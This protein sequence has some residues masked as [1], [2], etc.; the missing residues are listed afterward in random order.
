MPTMSQD[1][2]KAL[3]MHSRSAMSL[4]EIRDA[5]AAL[6]PSLD[7]FKGGWASINNYE[8]NL[9]RPGIEPPASTPEI[10]AATDVLPRMLR[11]RFYYWDPA[12]AGMGDQQG[13]DPLVTRRLNAIDVMITEPAEGRIG[14]LFSTRTPSYLGKGDGIIASLNKILQTRDATIKVDRRQSHLRLMDE[15]IFL[16]LA[17]QHRDRPQLAADIKLDQIAGISS[18]DTASRTADLRYGVD[19]ERSNFLTAVAEKDTLGPIDICFVHH[20]GEENHSYEVRLHV[21]GGFEVRRNSLHFPDMLDRPELM[22]ETSLFLAYSLIPRF[23]A[24][25][26]ADAANWSTQRVDVIQSAMAALEERYKSL[27]AVL[28]KQL[29]GSEG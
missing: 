4:E 14:L 21:D 5:M 27:K 2:V 28:E 7:G 12:P 23:N 25:Y 6:P 17:V 22:L 11:A 13:H 19:F 3:P 10:T 16:W 24:L 26:A 8:S 29:A 15:E 18:R 1:S 9:R 20:V